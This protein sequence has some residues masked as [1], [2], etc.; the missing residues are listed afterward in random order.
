M[1][2]RRKSNGK[3]KEIKRGGQRPGAGRP[4][5]PR[6][7]R[8][9]GGISWKKVNALA[10]LGADRELILA[11]T[12]FPREA[13]KDPKVVEQLQEEI[14]YGQALHKVDLLKDNWR[15][16]KGLDGSVNAVQAGL[17]QALGWDRPDSAKSRERARPDD[18]AAI[19]EL[20]RVAKR[21]RAPG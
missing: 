2:T 21:F 20:S 16:R 13:L 1:G 5:Q 3:S 9:P 4:V 12:R 19:A 15:L 8:G 11:A 7:S 18:E 6:S 17:R 14:A 10:Q